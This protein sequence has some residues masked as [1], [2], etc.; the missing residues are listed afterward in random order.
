[1]LAVSFLSNALCELE[2]L[3]VVQPW[4]R[5][6]AAWQQGCGALMRWVKMRLRNGVGA[7]GRDSVVSGTG[8]SMT[9]GGPTSAGCGVDGFGE[10]LDGV[11]GVLEKMGGKG[12]EGWGFC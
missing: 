10:L 3:G 12:W 8:L 1:M 2:L 7:E 5:D 4:P 6:G 9:S 11:L